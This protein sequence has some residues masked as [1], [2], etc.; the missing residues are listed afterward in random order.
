MKPP[1]GLADGDDGIGLLVDK[2]R[3][4][5][6][7]PRPALIHLEATFYLARPQLGLAPADAVLGEDEG[8]PEGSLEPD[9]QKAGEAGGEGV[10]NGGARDLDVAQVVNLRYNHLSQVGGQLKFGLPLPVP[11]PDVYQRELD[12]GE[13]GDEGM[14]P[15]GDAPHRIGIGALQDQAD[16]AHRPFPLYLT[17]FNI[18]PW[19]GEVSYST[20]SISSVMR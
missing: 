9:A 16:V 15:G 8:L 19:G 11:G 10:V 2:L 13:A 12:V 1:V 20:S 14:D 5:P 7:P 6:E 3:H 17:I 18:V 4:L